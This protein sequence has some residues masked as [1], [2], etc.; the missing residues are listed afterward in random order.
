MTRIVVALACVLSMTAC[1][2]PSP[3]MPS[4]VVTPM[5]P[6]AVAAERAQNAVVP[7]RS[8]RAD[9]QGALGET[10]VITFD[11]GYE[12][13]VYRLGSARAGEFVV[14]FEPSGVVA[15]TRMRP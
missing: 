14:L 5:R 8:T 13:W 3:V 10:L 4:A 11:N 7:G 15:K 12:V 6:K 9:V 2:A 1:E